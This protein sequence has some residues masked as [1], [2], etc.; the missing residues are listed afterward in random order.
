MRV[1]LLDIQSFQKI[2]WDFYRDHKRYFMW[3]ELTEPYHIVVSEIMLQQTQTHRVAQK[4]E[5]F[6]NA[7]PTFHDLARASLRDVVLQ[8]QGLGYNRR[9]LALH[10]LAQRVANEYDGELP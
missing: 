7:F 2:I 10:I 8:W 5:P 3:R 6:I 9:A 1:I 4:F